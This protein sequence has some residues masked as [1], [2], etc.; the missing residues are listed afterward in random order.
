MKQYGFYV[1]KAIWATEDVWIN[2]WI[3]S[4]Q[5]VSIRLKVR[6]ANAGELAP[7]FQYSK[8]QS[9]SGWVHPVPAVEV[10]SLFFPSPKSSH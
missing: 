9:A 10:Y 1:T 6:A 8:S 7:K 3:N 4:E 2:T 5:T